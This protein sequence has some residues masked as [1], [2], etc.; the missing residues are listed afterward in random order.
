[1][2]F[3]YTRKVLLDLKFKFNWTSCILTCENWQPWPLVFWDSLHIFFFFFS[4][5]KNYLFIWLC[6]VLVVAHGLSSCDAWA[7]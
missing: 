2:G 3:T 7:Q 5:L 6:W 1:M 4:N